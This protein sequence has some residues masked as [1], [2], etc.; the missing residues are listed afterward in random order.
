MQVIAL[1][2]SLLDQAV[3]HIL[4]YLIYQYASHGTPSFSLLDQAFL[5]I[6]IYQAFPPLLPCSLC[7]CPV[8]SP[9]LSMQVIKKSLKWFFFLTCYDAMKIQKS[10]KWF[11][12]L[13]CYDV[14]KI[15]M[16]CLKLKL[17]TLISLIYPF[18]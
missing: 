4:I 9:Q 11:F 5:H 8:H 17:H 6:L 14:M 10:L 13:T 15:N 2:P 3:L 7:C 18:Y 12:F 1:L 16:R